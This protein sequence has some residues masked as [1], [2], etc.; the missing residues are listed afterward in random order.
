MTKTGTGTLTFTN[1]EPYTGITSI[2]QGTLR[3]GD[4]TTNGMIS[5]DIQNSATLVFQDN[6]SGLTYNN[7]ISGSGAVTKNGTGILTLTKA[8]TGLSGTTTI[9]GGTLQLGDGSTYAT[10]GGAIALFQAART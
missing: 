8:S 7:V 4:G 9:N 2:N 10:L 5:S 6:G 3:L 1:A